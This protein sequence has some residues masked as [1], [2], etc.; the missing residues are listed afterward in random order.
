MANNTIEAIREAE[1]ESLTRERDARAKAAQIVDEARAGAKTLIADVASRL[2]ESDATDMNAADSEGKKLLEKAE[3]EAAEEIKALRE[4][5]G[6]NEA[7]AVDAVID[8]L[9]KGA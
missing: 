4:R 1:R 6:K 9:I 5:A 2:K 3:L 7:A 8:H